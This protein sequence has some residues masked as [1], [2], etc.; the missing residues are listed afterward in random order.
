MPREKSR[1]GGAVDGARESATSP[2]STPTAQIIADLASPADVATIRTLLG[3]SDLLLDARPP[4][5]MRSS[6]IFARSVRPIRTG[7]A[8]TAISWFGEAGPSAIMRP[9]L[10][11]RS[12][13]GLVN[14]RP[15]RRAAGVAARR[16][17]RRG[18]RV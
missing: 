18:R 16:T 2:G 17:D 9:D 14:G 1:A 12:L 13:A 6:A 15:D 11:C 3:S 5:I 10:V 7:L 8:I 4:A